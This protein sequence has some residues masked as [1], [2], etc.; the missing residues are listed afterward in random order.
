[1]RSM[2]LHTN[3][4]NNH[5]RVNCLA[6]I[7]FC[8]VYYILRLLQW[9]FRSIW[10]SAKYLHRI[11]ST[12][13]H[14]RIIMIEFAEPTSIILAY[15]LCTQCNSDKCILSR[16]THT[17]HTTHKWIGWAERRQ[18]R[19]WWILIAQLKRVLHLFIHSS[20]YYCCALGG[21]YDWCITCWT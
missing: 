4:I 10:W 8:H 14:F 5:H 3:K 17:Q 13:M 18:R 19:R 12:D 7:T 11:D 1:M 21:F 6:K 2:R 16:S 9:I 20:L 15:L